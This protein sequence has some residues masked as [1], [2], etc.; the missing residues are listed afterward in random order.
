VRLL[1]VGAHQLSQPSGQLSLFPN[2]ADVAPAERFDE[3]LA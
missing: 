1:G 3:R 2:P